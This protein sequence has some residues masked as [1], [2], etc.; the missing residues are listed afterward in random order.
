MRV[1][2]SDDRSTVAVDLIRVYL[3]ASL[4]QLAMLRDS[5][6][7]PDGA[8]AH[9]VTPGLREWY[10]DGDEE[11]L[12]YVAFTRAAQAALLV[13]HRDPSAPRRRVVISADLPS[14]AVD[15]TDPQLGDSSVRLRTAVPL[16]A[17]AAV[18]VDD[19]AAEEAIGRAA[20]AAAAALAGDEDAQFVVDGAE[21]YD[22]AWY[23]VSELDQLVEGAS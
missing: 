5:K 1:R 21:D 19:A 3:P 10:V 2:T 18:H 13:L 7:C 16:S 6:Q 12:E 22:L 23:D 15:T 17:V 11:E 9:A 14:S 20:E 8:Q 4:A